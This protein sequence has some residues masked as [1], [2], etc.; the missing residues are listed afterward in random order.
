MDILIRISHVTCSTK[1]GFLLTVLTYSIFPLTPVHLKPFI[2]SF[3]CRLHLQSLI[4]FS[5]Q[6]WREKLW[7]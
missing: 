4:T 6:I 1:Y 7:N 3:P 5:M 2:A